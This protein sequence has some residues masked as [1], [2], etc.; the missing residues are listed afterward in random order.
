MAAA[1]GLAALDVYENEQ[2]FTRA[3]SLASYW[4]S[5]A[6]S[7]RS[8]SKVIDIRTIGLVAGIELESRPEKFGARAFEVFQRCFDEGVLVRITADTIA[9]SPPLIVE[10]A[11]IDQIFETLAR[12]LGG[13]A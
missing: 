3:A 5:A 4:E 13:V 1:A 6:H 10:R 8:C 9:L 7:L 12:V 11:Q 2:L